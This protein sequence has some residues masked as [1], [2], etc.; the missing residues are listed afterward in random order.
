MLEQIGFAYQ[1][2][3][4]AYAHR[5]AKSA[6]GLPRRTKANSNDHFQPTG[7]FAPTYEKARRERKLD[8]SRFASPV[9][10]HLSP[11][12]DGFEV[13]VLAFVQPTLPNATESRRFLG[14]FLEAFETELR[15][16]AAWKPRQAATSSP[17]VTLQ[18]PTPGLPATAPRQT[19]PTKV[20]VQVLAKH[21]L[22]NSFKVLEEGPDKKPGILQFGKPPATL[23]EVDTTIEVYRHNNNIQSPQYRWDPPPPPS[24]PQRRGGPPSHR[25]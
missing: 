5:L 25:R 13:R 10:L 12:A 7:T 22:P 3:A 4:K 23:P 14:E 6:L 16:R 17:P 9:H 24:A 11:V 19:L 8:N 2:F 1:T 20:R 15:R 18:R 21:S